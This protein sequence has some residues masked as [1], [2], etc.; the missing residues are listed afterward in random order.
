MNAVER[1]LYKANHQCACLTCF[2]ASKNGRARPV[3]GWNVKHTCPEGTTVDL[4]CATREEAE[5]YAQSCY[6]YGHT[7]ISVVEV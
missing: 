7:N 1:A 3:R 5:D 6:E 4:T 2:Q